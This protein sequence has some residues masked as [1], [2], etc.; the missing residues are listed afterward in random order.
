VCCV[1]RSTV[2]HVCWKAKNGRKKGAE[3]VFLSPRKHI[4]VWPKKSARLSSK[5]FYGKLLLNIMT[6]GRFSAAKKVTLALREKF[7]YEG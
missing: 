2:S 4:H 5:M 7:A 3:K 1:S 6:K